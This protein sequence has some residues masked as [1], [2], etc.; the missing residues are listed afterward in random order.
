MA[1]NELIQ[2]FEPQN[3]QPSDEAEGLGIQSLDKQLQKDDRVA[4][5]ALAQIPDYAGTDLSPAQ[6][7]S[8][9]AGAR[10]LKNTPGEVRFEQADELAAIEG[11]IERATQVSLREQ[12][13]TV[14]EE[15]VKT[16]S[17][18]MVRD[19]L[20]EELQDAPARVLLGDQIDLAQTEIERTPTA[21]QQSKEEFL[22]SL[23]DK[24]FGLIGAEVTLV[25]D[26]E[27]QDGV[28]TLAGEP[29]LIADNPLLEEGTVAPHKLTLLCDLKVESGYLVN[30]NPDCKEKSKSSIRGVTLEVKGR[31][32]LN[33]LALAA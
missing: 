15:T 21:E 16:T 4:D 29:Q 31:V 24:E 8:L 25:N 33:S 2:D 28:F 32:D 26:V 9:R 10:E 1:Q 27:I 13:E 30:T 7:A 3:Q 23:K 6:L 19:D 12:V 17:R 11:K 22:L 18:V 20:E 5:H 14:A